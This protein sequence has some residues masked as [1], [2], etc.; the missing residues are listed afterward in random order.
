MT[1]SGSVPRSWPWARIDPELDEMAH[2][3]LTISPQ[4]APFSF[5]AAQHLVSMAAGEP[6]RQA[7]SLRG[8]LARLLDSVSG[9]PSA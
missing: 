8:R 7:G 1:P 5:D 9:T 3:A 6:Q 2:E 4:L